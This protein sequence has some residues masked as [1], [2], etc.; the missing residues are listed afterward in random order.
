MVKKK[1]ESKIR[2]RLFS[3]FLIVHWIIITADAFHAPF[4]FG[5]EVLDII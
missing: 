3:F 5:S 4:T 2:Y 1:Y